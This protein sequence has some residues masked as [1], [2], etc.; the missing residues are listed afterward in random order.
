MF[1]KA[2]RLKLRFNYKGLC[3]VEDLWDLPLRSLDFLFKDL[4]STLK[5]QKEESLLEVKSS[6]DEIT[7]LKIAIIKHIVLTRQQ[8]QKQKAAEAEIISKKQKILE[9]IAAKQDAGL[10]DMSLEDLNKLYETL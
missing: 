7:E 2:A 10:Q 4:N 5:A 1:E 6:E 8:E 3:T 9:I